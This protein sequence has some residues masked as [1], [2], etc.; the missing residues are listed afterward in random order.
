MWPDVCRHWLPVWVPLIS[1]APLTFAVPMARG[2][3]MPGTGRDQG[4]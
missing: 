4:S 2:A 3:G 1:L